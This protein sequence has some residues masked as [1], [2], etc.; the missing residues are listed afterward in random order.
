M[1]NDRNH[2]IMSDASWF[3]TPKTFRFRDI[4]TFVYIA[5]AAIGKKNTV[6]VIQAFFDCTWT[7]MLA[8]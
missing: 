6:F 8:R 1:Q 5:N 7:S 3:Q 4:L 2:H